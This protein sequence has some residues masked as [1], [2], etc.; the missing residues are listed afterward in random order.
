MYNRQKLDIISVLENVTLE[1]LA[2]GAL[3]VLFLV[4]LLPKRFTEKLHVLKRGIKCM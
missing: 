3:E 2:G 4:V 1:T